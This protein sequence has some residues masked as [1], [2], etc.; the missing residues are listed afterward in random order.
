MQS[1]KLSIHHRRAFK[2]R[3]VDALPVHISP[4]WIGTYRLL[5][6]DAPD[7]FPAPPA[8]LILPH[9]AK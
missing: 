6:N 7:D 2:T 5:G 8:T 3:W 1:L 9:F 4:C